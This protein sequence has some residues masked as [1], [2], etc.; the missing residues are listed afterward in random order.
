[1]GAS[2]K[3]WWNQH[4]RLTGTQRRLP[5]PYRP[6]VPLR[7][8]MRDVDVEATQR[9]WDHALQTVNAGILRGRD[10]NQ[11]AFFAMDAREPALIS[12]QDYGNT[13]LGVI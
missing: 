2:S 8:E 5:A 9:R 13:S 7:L 6:F 3:S 11:N 1:M 12:A 10:P 4:Y